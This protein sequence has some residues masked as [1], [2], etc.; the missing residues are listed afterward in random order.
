MNYFTNTVTNG[1]LSA[2]GGSN[3]VYAYGSTRQF[4]T[5]TFSNTNFWVDVLFNPSSGTANQPPTAVN[6]TGPAVTQNTPVTFATSTLLAN[7][8]D[9]NG[10]TL[11]VTGVSGATNGTVSLNT[12]NATITFT[13]AAN[14]TGSAGFTYAISDG[15]G[16]TSSATVALTV[17][18]P[19]TSP[20]SACSRPRR[21]RRRPTPTTP[22]RSSWV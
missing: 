15:R 8:T 17:S 9:P 16:G 10:D 7:D 11:T 1:P 21:R 12:T 18:A 19:G 2:A 6:D 14:Y 22:A 13:P 5:Q 4:P 20:R 3:G